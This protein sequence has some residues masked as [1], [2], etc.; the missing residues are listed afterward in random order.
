MTLLKLTS[1]GSA[2]HL[3]GRRAAVPRARRPGQPAAGRLGGAAAP[4]ARLG[5]AAAEARPDPDGRSPCARAVRRPSP[6]AYEPL[7]AGE[8]VCA[9]TR[10]GEVLVAV[11][12]RGELDGF[13]RR[14]RVERRL[15][16]AASAPGGTRLVPINTVRRSSA[17]NV[18]R[19]PAAAAGEVLSTGQNGDHARTVG[20]PRAAPAP[21]SAHRCGARASGARRAARGAAAPGTRAARALTRAR[22]CCS[23]RRRTSWWRGRRLGSRR[24]WSEACGSRSAGASPAG[25]RRSGDRW[26]STT[27]TTRTCS[28]RSCVR[29]GSSRCS[30]SR[31]SSA[32][33]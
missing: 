12:V 19:E 24:R 6:A 16:D 33:R 1:P 23:T 21:T 26:S 9:F 30:A 15:P 11:A 4:A 2:G 8:D 5:R 17:R 27:S 31:C 13:R 22:C 3:P 32:V 14:R 10:G 25:W 29:R 20:E 18:V 28:I 7:D